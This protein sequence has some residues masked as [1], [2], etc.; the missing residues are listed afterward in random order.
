M[1]SISKYQNEES[2]IPNSFI[3]EGWMHRNTFQSIYQFCMLLHFLG[4]YICTKQ[5]RKTSLTSVIVKRNGHAEN[6]IGVG[7]KSFSIEEV[8]PASH[9]LSNHNT[10]ANGISHEWKA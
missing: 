4:N 3:K 6:G 10:H 7:T 1:L 9:N 5:I 8:A 2:K